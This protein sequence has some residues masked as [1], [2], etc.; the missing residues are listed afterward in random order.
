[1]NGSISNALLPLQM[2]SRAM[3]GASMRAA[4]KFV[5]SAAAPKAVVK[6]PTAEQLKAAIEAESKMKDYVDPAFQFHGYPLP[7]SVRCSAELGFFFLI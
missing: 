6:A 1:M 4:T 5:R 7:G 2:L 3:Q